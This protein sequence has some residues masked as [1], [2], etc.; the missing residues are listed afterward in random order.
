MERRLEGKIAALT[1]ASKGLG[2]T[3]AKTLAR[4][5]AT[6]VL[7]ARPSAELESLAAE[8]PGRSLPVACDVSDPH[9]VRAAFAQLKETHGPLDLLIN[10]AAVSFLNSVETAS[11]EDIQAEIGTNLLGPIFTI[12]EA[13]PLMRGRDGVI[14]NVSSLAAR[15]PAPLTTLYSTTKAALE[16]LSFALR[17][18]LRRD[19]IR[20]TTLRLGA[21]KTGKG[22]T[23]NWPADKKAQYLEAV[24]EAGIME[25]TGGWMTP[26][27]ISE[28]VVAIATLAPEISPGLVELSGR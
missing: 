3:L 27:A 23:R 21:V 20:V 24:R 22:L 28:A 5:G 19:N 2:R 10:N 25:M 13:I 14:I 1:G 16:M 17:A 8:I 6:I 4:E 7:L 18:E 11:D 12:R 26:D 9:S 15:Q